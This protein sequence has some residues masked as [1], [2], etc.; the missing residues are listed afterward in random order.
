MEKEEHK[1]GNRQAR[2][3]ETLV[4]APEVETGPA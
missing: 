3:K 4:L 1:I 2:V